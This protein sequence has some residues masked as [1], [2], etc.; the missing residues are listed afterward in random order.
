M[1]L[2]RGRKRAGS[3]FATF[4]PGFVRFLMADDKAEGRNRLSFFY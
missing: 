3:P 1:L 2:R 4:L